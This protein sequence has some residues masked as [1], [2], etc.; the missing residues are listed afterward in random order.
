M[1]TTS[2]HG[3]RGIKGN[4]LFA[5]FRLSLNSAFR[6]DKKVCRNTN[7]FTQPW[8]AGSPTLLKHLSPSPPVLDPS[9]TLPGLQVVSMKLL[10][11][12]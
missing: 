6:E 3:V 9:H 1:D 10:G 7:G 8:L 5:C 11:Y 2:G 4:A 12:N